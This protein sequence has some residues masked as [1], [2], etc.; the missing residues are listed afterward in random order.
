MKY[1]SFTHDDVSIM[2]NF[3]KGIVKAEIMLINTNLGLEIYYIYPLNIKKLIISSLELISSQKKIDASTYQISS[4]IKSEEITNH[5]CNNFNRLNGMPLAYNCY[6]QS[7]FRQIELNKTKNIRV[8][9]ELIHLWCEIITAPKFNKKISLNFIKPFNKF[10]KDNP[11]VA[12]N[13]EIRKHLIENSL[14]LSRKN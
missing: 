2:E 3:L 11:S 14:S 9:I 13:I 12:N 5:V 7:L 1:L 8:I 10:L 4:F 6:I